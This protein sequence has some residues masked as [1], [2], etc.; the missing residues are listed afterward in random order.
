MTDAQ[1][2]LTSIREREAERG[3]LLAQLDLWANVQAQG[4][5]IDTVDRFGFDPSLLTRKQKQAAR[6]ASM[7]GRRDPITGQV[8]KGLYQGDRL[9]NGHY[10]CRV[11]NYVRHH[12][13]TQTILDPLLKAV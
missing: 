12:D 7:F 11:F 5:E 6:K 8:E 2:L 9:P 1:Q 10:T 13:G 4:I 3:R